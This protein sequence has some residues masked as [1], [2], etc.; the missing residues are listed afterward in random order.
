MHGQRIVQH[1]P[2][3]GWLRGVLEPLCE[4]AEFFGLGTIVC[5]QVLPAPGLLDL[6]CQAMRSGLPSEQPVSL[7][8]HGSSLDEVVVVA[9]RNIGDASLIVYA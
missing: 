1:V 9:E 3:T 7:Q 4:S 5:A 6:M 2:L 8:H